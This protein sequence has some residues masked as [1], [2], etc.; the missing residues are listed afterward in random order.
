MCVCLPI[1]LVAILLLSRLPLQSFLVAVFSDI[2]FYV[3]LFSLFHFF[4]AEF[5]SCPIFPCL[6]YRLP[7][8]SVVFFTIALFVVIFTTN[9]SGSASQQLQLDKLFVVLNVC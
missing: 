1:F 6:F 2:Y 8:F 4:V 5:S 7:I 9:H 3:A